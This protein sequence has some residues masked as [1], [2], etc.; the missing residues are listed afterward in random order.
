MQRQWQQH[1]VTR[2]DEAGFAEG[3]DINFDIPVLE[4]KRFR[5]ACRAGSIDEHRRRAA[6]ER[7]QPGAI[8]SGE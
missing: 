4:E 8:L 1:A 3:S 5:A 6:G 7:R 2:A